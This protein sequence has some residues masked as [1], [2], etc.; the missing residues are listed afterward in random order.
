[1]FNVRII[2]V[3]TT[4]KVHIAALSSGNVTEG[5]GDA[6]GTYKKGDK[7]EPYNYIL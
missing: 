4:L 6:T 3:F 7:A 5:T 1:M 2:S